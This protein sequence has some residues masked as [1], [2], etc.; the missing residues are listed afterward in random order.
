MLQGLQ[1]DVQ[2]KRPNTVCPQSFDPGA[3]QETGDST[4]Y[5]VTRA[6]RLTKFTW[7]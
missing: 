2:T 5:A 7:R 6:I 1:T 4:N 3:K